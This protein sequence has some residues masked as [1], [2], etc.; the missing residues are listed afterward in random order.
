[1]YMKVEISFMILS[2]FLQQK[3]NIIH[4]LFTFLA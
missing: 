4:A 1:M 2:D 3:W